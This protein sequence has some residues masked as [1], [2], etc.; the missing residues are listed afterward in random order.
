MARASTFTKDP[1]ANLDYSVDWSDWLATGDTIASSV[2]TVPTGLTEGAD[3]EALG[4][5]TVY[6]SGGTAGSDYAVA[7]KITT[8]AGRIDERTITIMVRQR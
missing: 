7:N 6:L 2:W 1:D 3:N 5:A 4:I 8:T